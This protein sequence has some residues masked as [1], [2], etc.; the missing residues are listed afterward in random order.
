MGLKCVAPRDVVSKVEWQIDRDSRFHRP[1]KKGPANSE[2]RGAWRSHVFQNAERM[3]SI[4]PWANSL[5]ELTVEN[6]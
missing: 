6:C 4:T 3:A 5:G 2:V 1:E